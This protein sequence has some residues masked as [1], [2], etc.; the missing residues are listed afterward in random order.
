MTK[1]LKLLKILFQFRLWNENEQQ[2]LHQIKKVQVKQWRADIDNKRQ[3]D[4]LKIV[5]RNVKRWEGRGLFKFK[6][7]VIMS[8]KHL[9]IHAEDSFS[10]PNGDEW[11][12]ECKSIRVGYWETWANLVN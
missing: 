9:L 4:L 2:K 5:W 6:V 11:M 1:I 7:S 12:N 8:L 3:L 10:F